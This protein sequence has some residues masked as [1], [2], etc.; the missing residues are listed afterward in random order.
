MPMKPIKFNLTTALTAWGFSPFQIGVV[1][2]LICLVAWY[3]YGTYLLAAKGRNWSNWRSLSFV[4]GLAMID[5]ALQSPLAAFTMSYFQAHALQHLILMAA[6]P[7]LLALGAPSTLFLQ[8]ATKNHKTLWLKILHSKPFAV[9]SHPI[10]V[11]FL[12]YG[13]MF[14]FFLTPAIGFAM[15]HM[16]LMD[17]INVGFLLGATLFWWPIVAV[18]PIPRWHMDY[19]AKLVNLLIGVPVEAFLGITIMMNHN[20]IAPMYTLASTHAGGGILLSMSELFS[21]VAVIPIFFQWMHSEDRKS[22][23]HDRLVDSAVFDPESEAQAAIVAVIAAPPA[24]N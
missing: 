8:T 23:R 3:L 24:R 16:A 22:L 9:I 15:N 6:A 21:V 14:A 12:Y 19:G 17:L 10:V 13:A 4:V 18:D 20:T 11:W 7:P 2:V 1:I 5:I